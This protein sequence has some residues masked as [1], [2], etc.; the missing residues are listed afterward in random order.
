[1]KKKFHLG[2]FIGFVVLFYF[3]WRLGTGVAIN[4]FGDEITGTV[5]SVYKSGS[6]GRIACRYSFTLESSTYSESCHC[7]EY[8]KGDTLTVLYLPKFPTYSQIKNKKRILSK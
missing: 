8:R 6:K 7:N 4:H 3:V 1:M 5:Q 2:N